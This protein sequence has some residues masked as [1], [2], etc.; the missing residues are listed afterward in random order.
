MDKPTSYV[1]PG[2]LALLLWSAAAA[3]AAQPCR[4]D[5]RLVIRST[6]CP[7]VKAVAPTT[8]PPASALVA[9]ADEADADAPKKR[10][11]AEIMREREAD[12]RHRPAAEPV[13]R[14]GAS[15]LRD[16]MGAL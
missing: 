8:R 16:R 7:V 4:I 12:I 6:P 15:V 11:I 10:T 13:Q 1:V 5:G 9:A 14:D 2:A 3:H